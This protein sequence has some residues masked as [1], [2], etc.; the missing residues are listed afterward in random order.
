VASPAT[1]ATLANTLPADIDHLP[2]P[3]RRPWFV[4]HP[5]V[6]LSV[7]PIG[8]DTILHGDTGMARIPAGTTVGRIAYSPNGL[9]SF[10][11]DNLTYAVAYAFSGFETLFGCMDQAD[12]YGLPLPEYFLGD[13]P[14]K[15]MCHFLKHF[16]F[17]VIDNGEFGASV[18]APVERVRAALARHQDRADRLLARANRESSA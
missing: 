2:P 11:P 17:D 15:R 18:F 7:F 16:D 12:A 9:R 8:F 1:P 10:A 14:E 3:A 4:R 6:G 13:A 5:D